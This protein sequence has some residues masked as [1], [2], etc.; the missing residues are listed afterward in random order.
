MGLRN[1]QMKNAGPRVSFFETKLGKIRAEFTN[2]FLTALRFTTQ[3][4]G[5]NYFGIAANN[6]IRKKTIK[7]LVEYFSGKLKSFN[8]KID[9]QGTEFQ[10]S[11]WSALKN[12]HTDKRGVIQK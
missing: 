2:D 11:V 12:F 9:F 1:L 7:Q 4:L 10:K 6:R 3:D 5:T 8:I